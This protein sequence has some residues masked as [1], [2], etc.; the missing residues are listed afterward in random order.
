MQHVYT[1][2]HLARVVAGPGFN[3]DD[4]GMPITIVV[5]ESGVGPRDESPTLAEFSGQSLRIDGARALRGHA[6]RVGGV[7]SM[8]PPGWFSVG[9]TL[10]VLGAGRFI[11]GGDPLDPG[12]RWHPAP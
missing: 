5:R 4:D 2:D 12:G 9:A 3:Q 11:R 6:G 8:P 1:I 7:A 10:D